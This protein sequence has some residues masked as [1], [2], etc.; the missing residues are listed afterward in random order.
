VTTAARLPKLRSRPL[1]RRQ[2]HHSRRALLRG[3]PPGAQRFLSAGCAGN[4]YFEWIEE[5][6]GRVPEHLSIEYYMPKPEGLPNNVTWIANTASDMSAVASASCDL[7]FSGQNLEHLSE[8]LL[9]SAR[10]L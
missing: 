8:F 1:A 5:T 9:E 3:I 10:V 2:Q 6:Y 4:C 7:V